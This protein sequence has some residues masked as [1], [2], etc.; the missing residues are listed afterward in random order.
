MARE[1]RITLV[2]RG[3]FDAGK[4]EIRL[5][6]RGYRVVRLDQPHLAIGHIYSD[7]PDI[8]II[9]LGRG[10]EDFFSLVG[11]LKSDC[12]FSTIPVI[13]LMGL[14]MVDGFDWV[15]F[16]LDDFVIIPPSYPILFS[17]IALSLARIQRVFDNNPLTKLPGNTSIQRAI[18]AA[19]GKSLAVCYVDINNFKPYND[20]YGF[21]QGDVVLRMLARIMF[22]AVK[23]AGGG[24]T[25]HIGGDD[26]VFIV[27]ME[28]AEGVCRTIIDN[29]D[30][31]VPDLFDSDTQ[32]AGHF[33]ACNRRGEQ[34]EV[35]LLGIAIGV[36][37]TD[38]PTINHYGKVA[39]VAAELKKLAKQAGKSHYAIDRR[40]S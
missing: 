24:F 27:P 37:P 9:D 26:F 40:R 6:S 1:Y 35:P 38:C 28:E 17:R 4:L 25:G 32:L 3:A 29:F 22:N 21:S 13:G 15:A 14:E 36:V 31:V 39:E 18:E 11:R 10:D 19:I 23:D 30:R 7:P 8:V 2:S 12:Y 34:E 5:Q 20:V 16:P 33:T